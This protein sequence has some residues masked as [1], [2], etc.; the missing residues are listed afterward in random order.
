MDG[1]ITGTRIT[2]RGGMVALPPMSL[3]YKTYHIAENFVGE[4]L[5]VYIILQIGG[6]L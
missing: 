1:V 5:H 4:N 3:A 2:S 6:F